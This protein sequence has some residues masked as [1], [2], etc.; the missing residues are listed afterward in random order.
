MKRRKILTT[1]GALA[2]VTLAGCGG[3]ADSSSSASGGAGEMG[4][5]SKSEIAAVVD[6][7]TFIDSQTRRVYHVE[8]AHRGSYKHEVY[9]C[10]SGLDGSAK[11]VLLSARNSR[12][13]NHHSSLDFST[14]DTLP[15]GSNPDQLYA[16]AFNSY[17]EVVFTIDNRAIPVK[18]PLSAEPNI[19]TQWSSYEYDEHDETELLISR[20]GTTPST[21]NW[22]VAVRFF[23]MPIEDHGSQ[24]SDYLTEIVRNAPTHDSSVLLD[25]TVLPVGYPNTHTK[26]Q[27]LTG[28]E[29][30][31][32]GVIASDN[33]EDTLAIPSHRHAGH[34]ELVRTSAIAHPNT[35]VRDQTLRRLRRHHQRHIKKLKALAGT[36][37]DKQQ[38]AVLSA[39]DE[40][41]A[42]SFGASGVQ[43]IKDRMNAFANA[44]DTEVEKLQSDFVTLRDTLLADPKF[45]EEMNRGLQIIDSQDADSLV[46]GHGHMWSLA[47]QGRIK[48]TK[49][50]SNF[51]TIGGG[52]R[53]SYPLM[54]RSKTK[55]SA[56]EIT[57]LN[58]NSGTAFNHKFAITLLGG[59][60]L[61]WT[62][63]H[64]AG[65]KMSLGISL[66]VEF[67][68]AFTHRPGVGTRLDSMCFDLCIDPNS[69]FKW[70]FKELADRISSMF[71]SRTS[72][73]AVQAMARPTGEIEM[74]SIDSVGAVAE[75]AVNASEGTPNKKANLWKTGLVTNPSIGPFLIG[76]L[77][78]LRFFWVNSTTLDPNTPFTRGWSW[79]TG[80]SHYQP[81]AKF[82]GGLKVETDFEFG[83]TPLVYSVNAMGRLISNI[84][85][86]SFHTV[87]SARNNAAIMVVANGAK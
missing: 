54:I 77:S 84:D 37:R 41:M 70:F 33:G 46:R 7:Y 30:H 44:L 11:R 55:F 48:L 28:D 2:G 58:Y 81:G 65:G 35:V 61:G 16:F 8:V 76:E 27:R 73:P 43:A 25:G 85:G 13:K 59:G 22:A 36:D 40:A 17:I 20:D 12:P 52:V 34:F 53:F 79:N 32:A 72:T 21:T 57:E 10:Y 86:F 42:T 9:L 50:T 63:D 15:S 64:L 56:T 38:R 26:Y 18:A 78:P 60:S 29:A 68:F 66:D 47:A 39:H 6:P 67:T 83:V 87:N 75:H 3:G 19:G 45:Q 71:G 5:E 23:R 31:I 62:S 49:K 1:A 74:T 14:L 51:A 80:V 24:R 69:S 82:L 4:S